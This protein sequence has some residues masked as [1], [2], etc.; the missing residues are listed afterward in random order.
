MLEK[1]FSVFA[2]KILEWRTVGDARRFKIHIFILY[3]RISNSIN[4]DNF[5]QY[6]ICDKRSSS[7]VQIDL[8]I[9]WV[10]VFSD[11]INPAH[12]RPMG[13]VGP[14][15]S[16][17][18]RAGPGLAH[19]LCSVKLLKI[20]FRVGLGPKFFCRFHDIYPRPSSKVRG[21]AGPS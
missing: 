2:R 17:R 14:Q 13:H 8:S 9:P 16:G 15:F 3:A 21:R 5:K 19:I 1:V 12:D 10:E 6:L 4:L 20:T 18:A 7:N 11:R